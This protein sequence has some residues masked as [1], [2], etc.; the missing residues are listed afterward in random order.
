[1]GGRYGGN[2]KG[3][4]NHKQKPWIVS[5]RVLEAIGAATRPDLE[6]IGRKTRRLATKAPTLLPSFK[7][8]PRK[9]R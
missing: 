5:L 1:M 8:Q 3:S 2:I 9:E 6:A 4:R 7:A